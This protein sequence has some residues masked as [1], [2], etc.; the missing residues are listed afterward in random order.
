MDT[1]YFAPTVTA[2]FTKRT[3]LTPT[4]SAQ[5]DRGVPTNGFMPGYGSLIDTPCGRIDRRASLVEPDVA[6]LKRSQINAMT[7]AC[8]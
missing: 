7:V 2:D 5:R 6:Y 3:S 4:A 8:Q 1:C